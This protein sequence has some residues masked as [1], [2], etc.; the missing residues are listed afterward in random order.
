MSDVATVAVPEVAHAAV[1]TAGLT[2][3]VS[4]RN[5]NFYYGDARA[6]KSISLALT[7]TR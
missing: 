7:R 4:M 2:E 5:L 1:D 6:L 3:K